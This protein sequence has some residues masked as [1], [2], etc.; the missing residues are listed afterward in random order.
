MFSCW[1]FEG[2]DDD[3]GDAVCEEMQIARNAVA[4][5]AVGMVN[6]EKREIGAV[7]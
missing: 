6:E 3:V 1:E 2:Y 4:G 7:S 5:D